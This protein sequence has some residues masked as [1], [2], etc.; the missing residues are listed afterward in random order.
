MTEEI[1]EVNT[2]LENAESLLKH[3]G[4][5]DQ[6]IAVPL[7]E[8]F[9]LCLFNFVAVNFKLF[10]KSRKNVHHHLTE[11]ICRFLFLFTFYVSI[12]LILAVICILVGGLAA[13]FAAVA[14][15]AFEHV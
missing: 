1:M 7:Q 9:F 5:P 4:D 2:K 14:C 12:S 11:A 10:A 15:S 13:A 6:Q 3:A 8:Y